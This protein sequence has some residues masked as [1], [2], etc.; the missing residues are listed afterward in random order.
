[1]LKEL[2]TEVTSFTWSFDWFAVFK[3]TSLLPASIIPLCWG[4]DKAAE[5]VW[6]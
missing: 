4:I 6:V 3:R 5:Y 1:M 2:L